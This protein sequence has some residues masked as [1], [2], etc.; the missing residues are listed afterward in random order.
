MISNDKRRSRIGMQDT[1]FLDIAMMTNINHRIVTTDADIRPNTCMFA[2][3]DVTND[4][5]RIKNK[6]GRI[7][8]WN[9]VTELVNRHGR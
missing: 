2:H 3:N 6:R 9:Q 5:G 7:N 4:V 1:A 8:A